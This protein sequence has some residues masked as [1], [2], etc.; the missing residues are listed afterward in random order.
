M[1][2]EAEARRL[3]DVDSSIVVEY[4]EHDLPPDALTSALRKLGSA[5]VDI[6]VQES[7]RAAEDLMMGII[8][9]LALQDVYAAN[10]NAIAE[11]LHIRGQENPV[12]TAIVVR[13][14]SFLASSDP[15]QWQAGVEVLTRVGRE[16]QGAGVRLRVAAFL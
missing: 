6:T 7:P 16:W 12:T 3:L 4:R 2:A 5:V 13:N 9:G 10:W 1:N 8:T 14:A 15:L 11:S